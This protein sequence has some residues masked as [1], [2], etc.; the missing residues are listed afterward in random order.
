MPTYE[1]IFGNEDDDLV[2]TNSKKSKGNGNQK[3]VYWLLALLFVD[4]AQH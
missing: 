2:F 1:Q 3:G 4:E